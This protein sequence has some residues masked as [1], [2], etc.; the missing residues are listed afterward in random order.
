MCNYFGTEGVGLRTLC[1]R[2]PRLTAMIG[3]PPT[4]RRTGGTSPVSWAIMMPQPALML[5][6]LPPQGRQDSQY[7]VIFHRQA[8]A[9]GGAMLVGPTLDQAARGEQGARPLEH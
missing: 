8:Y 5:A 2:K 3:M 7:G 1:V 6:A 9:K 4:D